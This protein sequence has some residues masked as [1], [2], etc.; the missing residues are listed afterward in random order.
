MLSHLVLFFVCVF[1]FYSHDSRPECPSSENGH[2]GGWSFL[3]AF[4]SDSDQNRLSSAKVDPH[5]SSSLSPSQVILLSDDIEAEASPPPHHEAQDLVAG[6]Q[7]GPGT[8]S[9]LAPHQPSQRV[10]SLFK[11][12]VP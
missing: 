11:V 10:V 8:Q 9:G 12:T 2:R 3:S 7:T 6:D 1:L 5:H 4:S